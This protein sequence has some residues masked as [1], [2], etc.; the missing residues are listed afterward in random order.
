ML[1]SRKT[2]DVFKLR[3]AR[4]YRKIFAAVAISGNFHVGLLLSASAENEPTITAN[5]IQS[6]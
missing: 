2:I 1:G 4:K 3:C 5:D 6:L